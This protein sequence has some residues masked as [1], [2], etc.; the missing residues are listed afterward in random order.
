MARPAKRPILATFL[1]GAAAACATVASTPENPQ[2]VPSQRAQAAEQHSDLLAQFGGAYEGP[3]AAYV[4]RVGQRVAAAA[5]VADQ[6][7]FTL[8]NTDVV[9]AFAVPGCYIYVTRGLLG[10]INSEAELA[11]VLGHEVGHVVAD[12][13]ERRQNRTLL[14]G[15]GALI[16]GVVTGSGELAQLAGQTAQLYTLQYSRGQEH[17]ADDLGI[18]YLTEAGYDPYA[19][20]DLL[21]ALLDHDQLESRIRGRDEANA[22][23]E[24]ARTHPLTAERIARATER[25]RATGLGPD[26]RPEQE[27]DYLAVLDGML[28]GDDPAQGFVT[29]RTFAH[30]QLR[31]AFEAPQGFALT[32]STRAVLIEGPGELRAQFSGGAL[33]AA[34]LEAYVSAVLQQL[35]GQTQAQVGAAQRTTVNG[36][37]TLVVPARAQT[38]QGAVDVVVAAYRFDSDSAYHFIGLAPAGRSQAFEP[39]FRS[40]RRLSA[41]EAA[42]LRPRRFRVVTIRS[43]ETIDDLA[44]RMAFDAHQVERFVMLNDVPPD[45]PLR[46][47]EPVKLVVYGSAGG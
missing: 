45:Q 47:G 30:P 29:G 7:T 38:Q 27:A 40:F 20:A 8:V 23:P 2:I 3:Q 12:H 13:S 46:P 44:S 28:Y 32:N 9:N 5:G 37:E 15:L 25:A 26:A 21:E 14:S 4:S 1:A 18:R 16:V 10:I 19:A 39:L 41:A 35:L 11:S 33:P 6:C 17:E 42:T 31:L 43:G 34:G 24:W 22:I 36:I